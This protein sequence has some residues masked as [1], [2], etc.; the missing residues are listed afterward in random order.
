MSEDMLV[1]IFNRNK[2]F[3]DLSRVY[4]PRKDTPEVYIKMVYDKGL[5]TLKEYTKAIKE[6]R[7]MRNALAVNGEVAEYIDELPYKWW[8]RGAWE[9]DSDK[10]TEELVDVLHF[11]LVAFDDLG[12]GP[13]EI[14]EAYVKKNEHNFERFEKKLGW[15][16]PQR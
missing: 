2:R 5:M 15:K 13:K 11:L 3:T 8:G 14:Y 12:L 7:V 10:A 4:S 9:I 1:D 16:I 6:L